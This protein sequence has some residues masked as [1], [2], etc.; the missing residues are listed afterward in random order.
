MRKPKGK[1]IAPI[2]MKRL[3]SEPGTR[4]CNYPPRLCKAL[5]AFKNLSYAPCPLVILIGVM[6]HKVMSDLTVSDILPRKQS[7]V[8]WE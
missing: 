2:L 4:A 6:S 1:G 7:E 8:K 5:A 3:E